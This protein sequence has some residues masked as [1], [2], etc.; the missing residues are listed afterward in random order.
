MVKATCQKFDLLKQGHF[1]YF[2]IL[3]FMFV[4][5]DFLFGQ[6]LDIPVKGYGISFGNSKKFTGLRFNFRDKRVDRIDG[7][8]I[9]LW[10][11]DENEDA[12]SRV[13]H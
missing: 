9:T 12:L 6:S 7:M 10:K 11:A 8:N 5:V 13:Q 4:E 3:I 1:V 2:F